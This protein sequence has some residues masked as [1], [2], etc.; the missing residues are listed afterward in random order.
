MRISLLQG[1]G[2]REVGIPDANLMAVAMPP[3][4]IDPAADE[5]AEIRRALENPIG[6]PRLRKLARGKQKVALIVSDHT[7]PTPSG[8]LVPA[9]LEE[10]EAAGVSPS[11][12][13]VV[14]AAG[15]HRPTRPEEMQRI[16][17]K[18][19][20]SRIRLVAHDSDASDLLYV[21]TT[22]VNRTPVWMNPVVA[23]ADLRL[24]VSC[25]EPHQGAGWS[26][27]AKNLLPGVCGRKTVMT[28]HSMLV[29][30]DV[31]LGVIEGNPFRADLEEAAALVGLDF[32]MGVILTEQNQISRLFTGHWIKA[33]RAAVDA[34]ESLL[35]FHL[36]QPADIVLASVGGAPRDSNLWQTEGKC[37]TRVSHAVREGGVTIVVSECAE[38]VGHP[39]LA[40]ALKSGSVDEILERFTTA[41]FTVSGNKA[42]RI[43][44][45]LKKT[46]IYLVTT[47]LKPEDFGQLPVR[48]FA[49]PQVALA[50]ALDKMGPSAQV[51][52]VPRSPGVLLKVG[53]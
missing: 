18:E 16:L 22:T 4:P 9:L 42:F 27:S 44:S 51:L 3:R 48:L 39:E 34:A 45:Q 17:G 35:S 40:A 7:R 33:H 28:H 14:F 53:E 6:S 1:K 5:A 36:S 2:Q 15:T 20:F 30:P 25:I 24:S 49:D 47:G 23:S 8:K 50:A 38:G 13:S 52:V 32:I 37:L 12:V 19:V 29:R 43:S 10:L 46:D 41:E 26:G 21:G 31:R 11:R